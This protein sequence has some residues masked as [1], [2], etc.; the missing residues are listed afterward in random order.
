L[1]KAE[2]TGINLGQGFARYF[3]PDPVDNRVMTDTDQSLGGAQANPL[4]IMA[5]CIFFQI[6]SH[7]ASVEFTKRMRARLT[8]VALMAVAAGSIL[9]NLGTLALGADHGHRHMM[10]EVELTINTYLAIPD[11]FVKIML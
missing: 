7:L 6:I 10:P 11:F 8:S 3:L 9:N 5:K 2:F 1:Y 4:G